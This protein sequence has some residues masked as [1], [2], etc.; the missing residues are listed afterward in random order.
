MIQAGDGFCFA[1][2][3]LAQIR[4]VGEMSGQNFYRDNSVEA[5]IAGPVH[6]AHPARTDRGENF[7]WP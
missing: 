3:A 6:L 1:V 2:E 4:A 5:G 7:V